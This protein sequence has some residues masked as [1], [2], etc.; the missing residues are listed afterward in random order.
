MLRQAWPV[1]RRIEMP[2]SNSSAGLAKVFTTSSASILLPRR[3]C[4]E[5]AAQRSARF[6][7]ALNQLTGAPERIRTSDPQIRSLV[8]YPA[9]LRARV[10]Q[11]REMSAADAGGSATRRSYRLGPALASLARG[12]PA[13]L[14]R[15][16]DPDRG[17][18]HRS[19]EERKKNVSSSWVPWVPDLPRGKPGVVQDTPIHAYPCPSR[20]GALA[21]PAADIDRAVWNGETE[22]GADG[23]FDQADLA[24]TGAHQ[25]G[26]NCKDEPGTPS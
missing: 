3:S 6:R 21:T 22:R 23:A 14:P 26:D 20:A 25:L 24:A 1:G 5:A 7:S 11:S 16:R 17:P 4:L 8:L 9:E 10:A 2:R 19:S 18:S 15:R 13:S 12:P